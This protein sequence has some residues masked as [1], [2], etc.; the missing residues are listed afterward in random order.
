MNSLLRFVMLLALLNTGTAFSSTIAGT[1]RDS[2]GAVVA[3]AQIT[4]HRDPVGGAK[5]STD[6][7]VSSDKNGQFTLNIAPGFYDLFVSASGFSPECTK[8]RASETKP[9]IYMP[10]LRADPLVVKEFGDIF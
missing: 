10:R 8:V 3:K 2:A 6:A 5:E 4:V 7:V 9:A 1:V